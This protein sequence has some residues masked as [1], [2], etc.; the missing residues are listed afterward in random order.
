LN[1][2]PCAEASAQLTEN[3]RP[4]DI[5]DEVDAAPAAGPLPL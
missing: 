4:P 1:G 5:S 2:L 3:D